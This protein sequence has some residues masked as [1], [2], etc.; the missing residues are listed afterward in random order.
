[1]FHR[2]SGLF[3]G[4]VSKIETWADLSIKI[5]GKPL[6]I[7]PEHW[8]PYMLAEL[9]IKTG[10]PYGQTYLV[11]LE[12]LKNV[13]HS[14]R[15]PRVGLWENANLMEVSLLSWLSTKKGSYYGYETFTMYWASLIQDIAE[16]ETRLDENA[17]KAHL[18]RTKYLLRDSLEVFNVLSLLTK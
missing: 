10:A 18:R 17:K 11:A 15:T 3:R 16:Y 1:M 13:L 7:S 4:P 9:V 14:S 12:E 6:S 2:L 5:D 8:Q